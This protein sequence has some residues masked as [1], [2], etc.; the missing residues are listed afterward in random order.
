MEFQPESIPRG[1]ERILVVDDD[2]T[3]VISLR[4][5]LERFGYKVT[6]L[7]DGQ[8][9]WKIFS[10]KP[11]E[12]DLVITDH[13]MPRFTGEDIA[14]E[15]TRLRPDIPIVMLTGGFR[16]TTYE[17]EEVRGMGF[18]EILVKP[19]TIREATELVRRVLDHPGDK[20]NP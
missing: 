10:E 16:F 18:R 12:F 3:I 8:E 17:S 15:I 6:A 2:E 14:C 4:N 7:T 11:S 19:F 5:M 9:A 13:V 1:N 20:E